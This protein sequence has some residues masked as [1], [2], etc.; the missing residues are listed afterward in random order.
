MTSKRDSSGHSRV[1]SHLPDVA[2]WQPRKD[3][4]CDLAVS[5]RRRC[6]FAE[7]RLL[8]RAAEEKAANID[9]FDS[10]VGVEEIFRDELGTLLPVR[11]EV[12]TG[13][14]SDRF[15]GTA[16]HCDCVIFNHLW[17]PA[18]KEGATTHS[19]RRHLPVEGVY[20][21][22]EVKQSL[23][24][25]TLDDAMEKLVVCQRLYRPAASRDRIVENR[26]TGTCLHAISNPMH[27]TVFALG[28]RKR[29]D[30]QKLIERFI[31]I[32]KMLKR[33]EMVTCLVVLGQGLLTWAYE[34]NDGVKPARF[35]YEDLY[36]PLRPA[37]TPPGHN[38]NTLYN[39]AMHLNGHLYSCVLAAEDI[40]LL[41]GEHEPTEVPVKLADDKWVMPEDPELIEFLQNPCNDQGHNLRT[42]SGILLPRFPIFPWLCL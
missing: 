16:G 31:N 4:N 41:Y 11:Y 42:S 38:W 5:Y 37:W 9:N 15:G 35:F 2:A 12:T 3:S 20:G 19:R 32:N 24:A 28:L 1:T 34:S 30:F 39:F 6:Q 10:G 14:I 13:V 17:F 22:I 8:V 25:K 33:R 18:I 23:D 40:A 27:T 26:E 36:T 29:A 21:V 7:R